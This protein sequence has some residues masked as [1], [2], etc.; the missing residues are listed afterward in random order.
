MKWINLKN[1]KC[2][3]CDKDFTKGM[4]VE[5]F[6]TYKPIVLESVNSSPVGPAIEKLLIHSCGFK[7]REKRYAQIVSQQ[8]TADLERQLDEEDDLL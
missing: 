4:K 1:N 7:I 5:A 8:V 3:Q 6:K 2:P